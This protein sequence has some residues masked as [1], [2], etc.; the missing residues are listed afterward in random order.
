[1]LLPHSVDYLIAK[2]RE[3]KKKKNYYKIAKSSVATKTTKTKKNKKLK[4]E[5][6]I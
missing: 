3:V 5:T 4:S 2:R 1:M 6:K